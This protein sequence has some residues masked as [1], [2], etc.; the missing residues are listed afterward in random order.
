MSENV[1]EYLGVSM[2]SDQTHAV[3]LCS[4]AQFDFSQLDV[5]VTPLIF[6]GRCASRGLSL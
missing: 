6:P 5:K 1:T 3:V 2:V 4:L